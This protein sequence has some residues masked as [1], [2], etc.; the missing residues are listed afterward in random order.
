MSPEVCRFLC[1]ENV[2]RKVVEALRLRG[3]DAVHVLDLGLMSADD[4]EIMDA[5]INEDRILLTRDYTDF[6]ELVVLQIHQGMEFPG[7]LFIS[8][9]IP[10]GDVGALLEAII[11]W[12]HQYES[13]GRSIRNTAAWLTLPH[14]DNDFDRYVREA[15]E[16]Y[17]A[18][19]ERI[20]GI[21]IPA[22][23]AADQRLNL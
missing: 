8:P 2:N 7:V 22:T 10:Q 17:L 23:G 19:V 6:G 4:G 9:S 20:T 13:E 3:V 1:D 5:A 16:P 14:R 15:T 12:A 21:T 11:S 18:A